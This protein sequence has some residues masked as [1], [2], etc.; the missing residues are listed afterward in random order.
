MDK[1]SSD[2][3]K[4][5]NGIS[6]IIALDSFL[7]SDWFLD[8]CVHMDMVMNLKHPCRH[9]ELVI[10]ILEWR[11]LKKFVQFVERI[12]AILQPDAVIYFTKNVSRLLC[13]QRTTWTVHTVTPEISSLKHLEQLILYQK[14]HFEYFLLQAL[15]LLDL[16]NL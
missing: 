9:R 5:W 3:K 2:I 10:F 11:I 8:L 4:G 15:I 1:I 12:N 13:F 14:G 16:R 6:M 7:E